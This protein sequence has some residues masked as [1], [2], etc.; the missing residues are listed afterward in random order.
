MHNIQYF[1]KQDFGTIWGFCTSIAI[2]V[3]VIKIL[4]KI[5]VRKKVDSIDIEDEDWKANEEEHREY[6]KLGMAA[7]SIGRYIYIKEQALI[8]KHIVYLFPFLPTMK[9]EEEFFLSYA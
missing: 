5:E 7:L 4:V 3:I 2:F 8:F 9:F 1:F 6:A